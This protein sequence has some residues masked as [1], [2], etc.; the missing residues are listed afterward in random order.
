VVTTASRLPPT[1]GDVIASA[2]RRNTNSEG[3]GGER[4]ARS[5]RIASESRARLFHRWREVSSN[6]CAARAVGV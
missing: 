3:C 6:R 4:H 2:L 5:H 1:V